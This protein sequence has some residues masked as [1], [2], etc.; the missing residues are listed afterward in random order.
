MIRGYGGSRDLKQLGRTLPL[1]FSFHMNEPV[2][3]Q[4]VDLCESTNND[5]HRCKSRSG[6][7]LGHSGA[8]AMNSQALVVTLM[9]PRHRIAVVDLM[10]T[11]IGRYLQTVPLTANERAILEGDLE[12][13]WSHLKAEQRADFG[14]QDAQ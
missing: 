5:G 2:E 3:E 10:R 8:V 7:A 1:S 6:A 4:M 14:R 9:S 11:S 13:G 12:A